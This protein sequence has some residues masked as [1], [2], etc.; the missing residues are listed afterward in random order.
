MEVEVPLQD[1]LGNRQFQL[2][3]LVATPEIDHEVV[4]LDT[5]LLECFRHAQDVVNARADAGGVQDL[6]DGSVEDH[7]RLREVVLGGDLRVEVQWADPGPARDVGRRLQQVFVVD[8]YLRV[9]HVISPFVDYGC[10]DESAWLESSTYLLP[11]PTGTSA[12]CSS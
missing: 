8:L 5:R 2:V 4:F 6:A 9:G 3:G 12:S 11:A 7:Q 1:S 10:V